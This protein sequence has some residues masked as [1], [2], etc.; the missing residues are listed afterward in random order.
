M[1]KQQDTKDKRS[2]SLSEQ[3]RFIIRSIPRDVESQV[4]LASP[5]LR[6]QLLLFS[7]TFSETVF[8]FIQRVATNAVIFRKKDKELK[9]ENVPLVSSFSLF[10]NDQYYISCKTDEDKVNA[11][12]NLYKNMIVNQA[13]IFFNR[14]ADILHMKSI[15][16]Q[17]NMKCEC[18]FGDM[19]P[20][21][22]DFIIDNYKNGEIKVYHSTF[23]VVIEQVL[24]ATNVIARG[25]DC[26]TVTLVVNYDIPMDNRHVV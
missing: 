8:T 13:I 26:S 18:L 21:F 9:L 25:F 7:A 19:E 14:T 5:L 23:E 2:M 22:R 3:A 10:S 6:T 11:I 17:K 1:F 24:L 12:M 4:S 16:D 15:F 20:K